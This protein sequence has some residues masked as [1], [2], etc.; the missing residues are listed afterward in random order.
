MYFLSHIQTHRYT[1][2]T[3]GHFLA[4]RAIHFEVQWRPTVRH[5]RTKQS[6]TVSPSHPRQREQ[7][8]LLDDSQTLEWPRFIGEPAIGLFKMEIIIPFLSSLFISHWT[9]PPKYNAVYIFN[10]YSFKKLGDRSHFL[11]LAGSH[12]SLWFDTYAKAATVLLCNGSSSEI[13]KCVCGIN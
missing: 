4:I 6:I 13:L 9:F 8:F 11:V 3:S 2:D 7:D 10:I 5:L 12:F 1:Q